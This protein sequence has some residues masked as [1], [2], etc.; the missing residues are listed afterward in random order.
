MAAPKQGPKQGPEEGPDPSLTIADLG[1]LALIERLKPFCAEG[2]VGDDAALL[3]V[4]SGYELVV[5]TDVLIDGVHFSDRTTPA[6]AVG[7]RAVAANLS[8]LAAMGAEP[9]GITVGL[10]LLAQTPWQWVEALYQGMTA[11]LAT[12]GGVI[13]GGDLCRAA[14]K[15]VAITAVGQVRAGQAIRRDTAVPG[16]SVVVTG[17]HGASRAGL[18]LLLGEVEGDQRSAAA[19]GWIKAHQTP[20]PRFDAIAQLHS[21]ID[22][23]VPY[24]T[25]AGMDSS[26][27]LANALLQL[28]RSSQVGMDIVRSHIPLPPGLSAVV[29]P[30]TAFDWALYGGEDFE[31][32]LCLPPDL[33]AKFVQVSGA[34]IGTTTGTGAVQ[35]LPSVESRR[36]ITLTHQSFKHF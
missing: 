26:D 10:G 33:A 29:G 17:A 6:F 32:V 27:G 19:M 12:Y 30:E 35:L 8:D 4:A 20:V 34:I 28:S 15:T 22:T 3:V 36:R 24:P 13:V 21:L 23:A 11:C 2:V 1:E 31:L 25:M 9:L 16:L 7:Y 14:Q 18:A 5:T